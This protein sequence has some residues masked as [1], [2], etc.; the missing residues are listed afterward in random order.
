MAVRVDERVGQKEGVAIIVKEE[1]R[2][3]IY[4]KRKEGLSP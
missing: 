1:W 3:C 4:E 2:D